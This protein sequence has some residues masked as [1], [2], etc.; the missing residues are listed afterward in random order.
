M[1]LAGMTIVTLAIAAPAAAQQAP[2][3]ATIVAAA[4]Q[5]SGG[6]AWDNLDGS[7]ESGTHGGAPYETWLDFHSY[8]MRSVEHRP[9]GAVARGFNGSAVW[10]WTPKDG[11]KIDDSP[12]ARIEAIV[13]AYVATGGYFFPDRFPATL[14]WKRAVTEGGRT[15]DVIEAVPQGARAF[16]LWFD[17]TSH[18]LGRIV[19]TTG[20]PAVSVEL[21]DYRET[22]PVLIAYAG[23]IRL[24]D[25][26]AADRG[27]VG[28]IE[29][30]RIP[31]DQF[32]PPGQ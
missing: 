5:A 24:P 32:D 13:T 19:D 27:Q 25:G 20:T 3:A 12:A 17:R 28:L 31:R 30:R 6:A 15:Y 4:K 11:A 18:L 26:T 22:G 10:R 8:G 21:S 16:E 14:S 2:D 1:R 23:T 7:Y 9:G 29:L